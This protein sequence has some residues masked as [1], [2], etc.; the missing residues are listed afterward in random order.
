MDAAMPGIQEG[1]N[2]AAI[3]IPAVTA[4]KVVKTIFQVI[5]GCTSSR[6]ICDFISAIY[7]S[8]CIF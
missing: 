5:P 6:L 2:M 3:H 1:I 7:S 8:N 4:R